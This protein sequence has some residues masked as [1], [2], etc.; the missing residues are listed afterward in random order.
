MAT[1]AAT[2]ESPSLAARSGHL[3]R[4]SASELVFPKDV[5]ANVTYKLPLKLTNPISA[6]VE[7]SV[8]P[9]NP[10]RYTVEPQTLTVEPHATATVEVKL[11]MTD[12]PP[13]RRGGGGGPRAGTFKDAFVVKSSLGMQQRF[14]ATFTPGVGAT[15]GAAVAEAAADRTIHASAPSVP[16]PGPA[17][18]GLR[19]PSARR[20]PLAEVTPPLGPAAAAAREQTTEAQAAQLAEQHALL[21][22]AEQRQVQEVAELARANAAYEA[23]QGWRVDGLSAEKMEVEG[24]TERSARGGTGGRTTTTSGGEGGGLSR[25]LG[26]SVLEALHL[27]EERNA[28]LQ[29][30]VKAT[31]AELGDSHA[32]LEALGAARGALVYGMEGGGR[33]GGGGA[34]AGAGAVGG[35][36]DVG[37]GEEARRVIERLVAEDEAKSAR[38]LAVLHSKDAELA[39]LAEA[40]SA[41]EAALNVSEERLR[42]Q[43]E[44]FALSGDTRMQGGEARGGEEEV[45][46]ARAEVVG[47]AKELEA[48]RGREAMLL[49]EL[50]ACKEEKRRA[51]DEARDAR[52]QA[53]QASMR[54]AHLEAERRAHVR[55]AAELE[56][57]EARLYDLVESSLGGGAEEGGRAGGGGG[58]GGGAAQQQQEEEEEEEEGRAWR[59]AAR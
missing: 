22:L 41:A 13:P 2:P 59:M 34:G 47:M 45:V 19:P 51:E 16:S 38:V 11:Y 40:L 46:S 29:E 23:E 17:S 4:L 30:E 28:A 44:A 52:L 24:R 48:S 26:S 7:V 58:G 33:A 6:P 3:L 1:T 31:A 14:F 35:L 57:R 9:G 8:R 56:Q 39:E 37:G 54:V 43:K 12:L 27:L 49:A 36:A 55:Q 15:D 50:E 20:P 53:E 10:E 32:Q 18:R 5:K 42:E 25:E 21:Q